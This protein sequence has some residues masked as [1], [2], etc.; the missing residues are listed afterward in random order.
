M[1][2]AGTAGITWRLT[3]ALPVSR[4]ERI[5]RAVGT[6]VVPTGIGS[7]AVL[8]GSVDRLR[9]LVTA[10]ST[11]RTVTSAVITVGWWRSPRHGWSGRVGWLDH[12]VGHR[13]TLPRGGRGP[14]VVRVTLRRPTQLRLV[15]GAAL[16]ALSPTRPLPRPAGAR[17]TARDTLPGFLP[18][19]PPATVVTGDPA[20][21]D[22]VRAH[23]LLLCPP[24]GAPDQPDRYAATAGA[25][26]YGLRTAGR[27]TI[28]VDAQRVN[29]RGRTAGAYA[30]DA[31]RVRLDFRPS[32]AAVD[33]RGPDPATLA[34]LRGVGVVECPRV[35]VNDPVAVAGT[36]VQLAMTGAVLYVPHLPP[37][38]GDLLGA[39][40]RRLVTT[41]VDGTEPLA[42]EVRSVAQRRAA[43]RDHGTAFALPAATG[44]AFPGL[45]RPPAVSALLVTRRLDMVPGALRAIAAQT[46]PELEIVLCLHGVE[47]PEPLRASLPGYDRPIELVEVPAGVSF[48][49]A[50][51]LAT[52]RARGS[53]VT[54]FDDDDTYGAE[55]VWDLVLARQFSGA[56]LVGKGAEFVFLESKGITVRRSAGAA[57]SDAQVIAGGTMMMGRGDLEEVGGWRPVPGSVDLGLIDRVKRHGGLIFRT[58]PLGYVYHRRATGHTWDPGA[59]YFQKNLSAS[60]PA[61]PPYEEFGTLLTPS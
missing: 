15:V 10:P 53:L 35:P 45:R 13:V 5:S 17:L 51:G 52:A 32:G 8:A 23:D 60:W 31:P 1:T 26:P 7:V 55:H 61:L 20:G 56:A 30:P 42:L 38:V 48:G 44:A 3:G 14:A 59:A 46:Y 25:T 2:G 28:L 37:T 39:E 19:R 18:I 9:H 57:E 49:E 12:L 16:E 47:A 11:L 24:G 34:A 50:L 22:D 4:S 58:H 40:L 33:G 36:F 27:T 29:P 54:K 21:Q 43:M 41:V 6:H